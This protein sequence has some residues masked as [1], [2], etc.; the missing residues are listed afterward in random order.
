MFEKALM[1]RSRCF[2][3]SK[4]VG[5][6]HEMRTSG[7]NRANSRWCTVGLRRSRQANERRSQCKPRV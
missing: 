2:M 6:Y 5:L 3:Y 4:D 1:F 7:W